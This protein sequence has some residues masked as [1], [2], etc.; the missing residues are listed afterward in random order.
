MNDPNGPYYFYSFYLINQKGRELRQG[1]GFGIK[2]NDELKIELEEKI[3]N[4]EED[5]S[6]YIKGIIYHGF[7][8]MDEFVR[9]DRP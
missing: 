3:Q 7:I 1:V 5:K 9:V 6:F 4:R 2:I 8:T